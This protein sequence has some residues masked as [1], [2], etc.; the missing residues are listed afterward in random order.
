MLLALQRGH[1]ERWG[2][3]A[4][5]REEWG[6]TVHTSGLLLGRII[7]AHLRKKFPPSPLP[8]LFTAGQSVA[9]CRGHAYH[10]VI[11]KHLDLAS[12]NFTLQLSRV[13]TI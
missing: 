4:T 13:G 2:E 10:I 1:F 11:F 9:V 7:G 8:H 3:K 6:A 5:I 12:P